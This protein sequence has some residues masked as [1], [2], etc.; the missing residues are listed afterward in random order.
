MLGTDKMLYRFVYRRLRNI[1]VRLTLEKIINEVKYK[2]SN[3]SSN[4]MGAN[5]DWAQRACV[6]ETSKFNWIFY[7][8]QEPE[9]INRLIPTSNW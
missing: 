1:D 2:R 5:I 7:E 3:M 8:V 4:W 9:E 6:V